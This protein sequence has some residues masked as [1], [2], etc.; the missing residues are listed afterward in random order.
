MLNDDNNRKEYEEL[1]QSREEIKKELVEAEKLRRKVNDTVTE[2]KAEGK[3]I[4]NRFTP[5]IALTCNN[6]YD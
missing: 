3:V 2:L 4:I 5:T 1:R 6:W